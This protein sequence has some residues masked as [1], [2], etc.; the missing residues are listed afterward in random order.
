MELLLIR[1]ARPE[2]AT[3]H[4]PADPHL[5]PE[6]HRQAGLLAQFLAGSGARVDALYRSPMRRAGQTAAPLAAA[7][8]LTAHVDD[9]LAEFDTGASLYIPTEERTDDLAALWEGLRAGRWDGVTIDL[10]AFQRRVVTCVERIVTRHPSQVVALVCHFGVINAYVADV[11]G[12]RDPFFF[13]PGYTSITRVM[14]DQEGRR[15]LR[16]ANETSHLLPH[17]PNPPQE[18]TMADQRTTSTPTSTRLLVTHALRVLGMATPQYVSRLTGLP[19]GEIADALA[20]AQ[21]DD[22]VRARTG[23][24]AGWSLT[25]AGRVWHARALAEE[26]ERSGV[27]GEVERAHEAFVALN[28]PFKRI[29]TSWQV[30]DAV[31]NDHADAAYDRAVLERLEALHREA[32]GLTGGLA[33][34]L[35]R[36]GWYSSALTDAR[37]RLLGG[38]LG[39]LSAPLSGSYHDLWMALH[40]DLLSTL[41]RE[42]SAKDGH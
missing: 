39:A 10:D 15:S 33:H 6:G 12:L 29:C 30:K 28:Q 14:A 41:G 19:E 5:S 4:E 37:D 17:G 27:R 25:A 34:A 23:R 42:R 8:G 1:H 20:S 22:L 18:E 16:S 35:P 2:P 21:R 13:E 26:L 36:F 31:P 11:L 24:L 3:A 7:T 38:D 9:G 32:M 40:Q